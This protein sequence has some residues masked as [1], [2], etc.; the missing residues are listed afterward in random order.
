MP[1]EEAIMFRIAS[2]LALLALP[3]GLAGCFVPAAYDDDA[4]YGGPG[5]GAVVVEPEYRRYPT[6][7][8]RY[9]VEEH[10]Y[11]PDRHRAWYASDR[12]RRYDRNERHDRRHD[13][14]R[15]RDHDSDH[16]HD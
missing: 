9:R 5:P 10:V 15:D 7:E 3:L 8:P 16:R 13:H 1:I 6:Y 4:Y 14:D 2:Y 11:V 12:S